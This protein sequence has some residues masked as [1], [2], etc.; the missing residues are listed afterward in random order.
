MITHLIKRHYLQILN[1]IV[2]KEQDDN[3]VAIKTTIKMSR[4]KQNQIIDN[5]ILSITTITESQ[6]SLSEIDLNVLNEALVRLQ[7]LKRK[8]GKTYGQIR[9]EIG[10]I[11]G[12]LF[13][14]F[15]KGIIE[16]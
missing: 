4:R 6:Y 3:D 12:L 8:K 5:V 14:I 9:E 15:A 16:K 10:Q 1:V 2:V 7:F 11:I 13:E